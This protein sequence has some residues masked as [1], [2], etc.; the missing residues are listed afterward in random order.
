M[1]APHELKKI[2][3]LGK[4]PILSVQSEE[5]KE[6]LVLAES[7][8]IV[9]YIV[10]HLG[11]ELAPKKWQE[12]KENSIGGETEEWLRYRYFMNYAEG[13]IMTL[14]LVQFIMSSEFISTGWLPSERHNIDNVPFRHQER[15]S[16]VLP[17]IHN[18]RYHVES[19]RCLLGPEFQDK[20]RFPRK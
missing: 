10:D 5:M 15:S 14:L 9:E 12:G 7:S 20:F 1:L 2:H 3:P 19:R 16:P 17:Q 6:P 11:P 13:T 8:M 4:S 18:K